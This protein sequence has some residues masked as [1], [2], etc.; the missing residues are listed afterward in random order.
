VGFHGGPRA[1]AVVMLKF[2]GGGRSV[3]F[4]ALTAA[5]AMLASEA[6]GI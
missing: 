6:L 1:V 4:V 3:C 2:S 5:S